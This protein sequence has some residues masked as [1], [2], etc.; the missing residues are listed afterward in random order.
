MFGVIF[1][2][3]GRKG[4]KKGA[5]RL[6]E[7]RRAIKS[8]TLS[9]Q[10]SYIGKS[11]TNCV[12]LA[13]TKTRDGDKK[14]ST[15]KSKPNKKAK[16]T[17]RVKRKRGMQCRSKK[18]SLPCQSTKGVKI[19]SPDIRNPPSIFS[20]VCQALSLLSILKTTDEEEERDRMTQQ[21]LANS[22]VLLSTNL[23]CALASELDRLV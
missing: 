5:R 7:T 13:A 18:S 4:R 15:T 6:K 9:E 21:P 3:V 17:T 23:I 11:L 8:S 2:L 12:K 14:D 10:N 16:H 1:R 22:L 19:A 20:P